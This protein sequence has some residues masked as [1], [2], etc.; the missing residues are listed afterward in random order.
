MWLARG[1]FSEKAL[2]EEPAAEQIVWLGQ[3]LVTGAP[4]QE[5]GFAIKYYPEFEVGINNETGYL[6]VRKVVTQ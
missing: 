6:R 1:L 5:G 3:P 4:D 2:V